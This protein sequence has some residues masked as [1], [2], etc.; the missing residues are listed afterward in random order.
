MDFHDYSKG[1]NAWCMKVTQRV[2]S[3]RLSEFGVDFFELDGIQSQSIESPY[4]PASITPCLVN[5]KADYALVYSP[6]H[7]EVA[8]ISRALLNDYTLSQMADTYKKCVAMASGVEVKSAH[9]SNLEALAQLATWFAP[10]FTKIRELNVEVRQGK[11][12]GSNDRLDSSRARLVYLH[13][14]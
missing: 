8:E 11:R 10:G 1:E 7:P 2:L 3:Y 12:R 6:R 14:S 13:G 9:G 4:L 5:K